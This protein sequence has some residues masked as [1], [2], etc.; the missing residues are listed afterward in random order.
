MRWGQNHSLFPFHASGN[1]GDDDNHDEEREGGRDRQ[2]KI[3]AEKDWDRN[4]G[5][6]H[7]S[8]LNDWLSFPFPTPLSSVDEDKTTK[9]HE[10]PGRI[11][12]DNVRVHLS[13]FPINE[14]ILEMMSHKW[15]TFLSLPS[16]TSHFTAIFLFQG[17]SLQKNEVN[18]N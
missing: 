11:R 18:K 1:D 17:V 16:F 15:V 9:S 10:I 6:S 14:Q 3:E 2:R 8:F 13:S 5:H 7:L 4:T 12:T